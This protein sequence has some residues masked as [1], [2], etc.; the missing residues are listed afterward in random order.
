MLIVFD[1][2]DKKS[3]ASSS[4][5]CCSLDKLKLGASLFAISET[6]A[7]ADVTIRDGEDNGPMLD[8]DTE[9]KS[10]IKFITRFFFLYLFIFLILQ[11][12]TNFDYL[13]IKIERV[14]TGRRSCAC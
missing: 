1:N 4:S 13:M 6:D 12:E 7:N 3:F 2:D 8:A 14:Y 10:F 5:L 9:V 11:L